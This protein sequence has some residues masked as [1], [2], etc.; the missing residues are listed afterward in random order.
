M[1]LSGLSKR[2]ALT[3]YHF[4]WNAV[5]WVFPPRC[6][7]CGQVGERWCSQCQGIWYGYL[8]EVDCPACGNRHG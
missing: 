6:G 4:F 8:L 5:D 2:P 1:E 7:G 3:A